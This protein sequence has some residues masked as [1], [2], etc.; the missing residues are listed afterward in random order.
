MFSL[1]PS[2][3]YLSIID[4]IFSAMHL[5][6]LAV[7]VCTVR[8]PLCLFLVVLDFSARNCETAVTTSLVSSFEDRLWIYSRKLT[9]LCVAVCFD[10][11]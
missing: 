6:F 3:A 5:I 9:S 4:L 10:C 2:P 8:D 7:N 1:C 11:C